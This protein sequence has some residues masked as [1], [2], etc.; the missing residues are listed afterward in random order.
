MVLSIKRF[1]GVL[2]VLMAQLTRGAACERLSRASASSYFCLA[3]LNT[4]LLFAPLLK[5]NSTL[6]FLIARV[7]DC[8]NA[9]S[10][11]KWGS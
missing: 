3:A 5:L 9:K 8:N 1:V 2:Q 7:H 10:A 6:A 4:Y 11:K